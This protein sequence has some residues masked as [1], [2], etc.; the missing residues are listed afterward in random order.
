MASVTRTLVVIF[1]CVGVLLFL[2]IQ[3]WRGLYRY[4]PFAIRIKNDLTNEMIVK[5]DGHTCGGKV[6]P[7]TFL[8]CDPIIFDPVDRTI[9]LSDK[10]A[11]ITYRSDME[12]VVVAHRNNDNKLEPA[13]ILMSDIIKSAQ[14]VKPK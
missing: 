1:C 7:N 13:L 11:S 9:E 12:F 5:I 10:A 4:R 2:D 6:N 14:K 3:W 8:P